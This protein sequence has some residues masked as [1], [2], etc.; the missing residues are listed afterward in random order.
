MAGERS[1]VAAARTPRGQQAAARRRATA[2]AHALL[3][4]GEAGASSLGGAQR[5]HSEVSVEW[6]ADLRRARTPGAAPAAIPRSVRLLVG[7]LTSQGG[8]LAHLGT[9]Q[10]GSG[11]NLN[12][13]HRSFRTEG[14]RKPTA[15]ST[16]RQKLAM[17]FVRPRRAANQTS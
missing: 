6:A 8:G 7:W 11:P 5:F 13:T 3:H 2:A 14:R 9:D 15:S 1:N 12:S 17:C 4:F 16:S 10:F